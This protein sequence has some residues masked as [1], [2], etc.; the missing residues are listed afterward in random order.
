MAPAADRSTILMSLHP[1]FADAILN[2]KKTVEF[3]RRPIARQV[4]AV[5][6][7]STSPVQKVVG[8]FQVGRVHAA[9]PTAIWNEHGACGEISRAEFRTYFEGARCAH[10]IEVFEAFKLDDPILLEE[11]SSGL[12]PPQSFS[13]VSGT[14]FSRLARACSSVAKNKH[15][16]A[17]RPMVQL[18]QL[19]LAADFA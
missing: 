19:N 16:R 17:R 3:R 10:A 4:S 2:G 1:R 8:Y 7:Y 13:Y 9:S 14:A 11:F 12:T 5:V 6:I 18:A 15:A